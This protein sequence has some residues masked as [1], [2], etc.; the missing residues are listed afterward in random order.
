MVEDSWN[1]TSI[2]IWHFNGPYRTQN[3]PVAAALTKTFEIRHLSLST[4]PAISKAFQGTV[5]YFHTWRHLSLF[6]V[7]HTR[8]APALLEAISDSNA[9]LSLKVSKHGPFYRGEQDLGTSSSIESGL[10]RQTSSRCL[11]GSK[12]SEPLQ[13]AD[14]LKACGNG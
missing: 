6:F 9:S 2:S 7:L 4:S 1:M 3:A 14:P 10:K 12:R 5:L 8:N 11:K 13:M